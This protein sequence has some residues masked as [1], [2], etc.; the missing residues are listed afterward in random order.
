MIYY[1]ITLCCE[2][3]Q[4]D[5]LIKDKKIIEKIISKSPLIFAKI[6]STNLKNLK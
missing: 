2:P 5:E 6:I 1:A 4:C 3:I